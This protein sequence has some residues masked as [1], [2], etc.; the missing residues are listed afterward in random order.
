VRDIPLNPMIKFSIPRS[1]THSFSLLSSKLQST[2]VERYPNYSRFAET[3]F[4]EIVETQNKALNASVK[5]LCWVMTH[6]DNHQEKAKFVM[7]TW[8]KRCDKFLFIS[9]GKSGEPRN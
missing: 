6:P 9:D 7:Q 2:N 4:E 3:K 8:G 1:I 5:L